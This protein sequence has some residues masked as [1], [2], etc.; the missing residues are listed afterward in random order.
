MFKR[1]KLCL[2]LKI[3]GIL[4][5]ASSVAR[6]EIFIELVDPPSLV[7]GKTN[8]I[9]LAGNDLQNAV[10]LWTSLG[11]DKVQ[12]KLVSKSDPH[13][14]IFDVQV[15][16]TTPLGFY[17]LRLATASGLSNVHLFL[18]D[19]LSI[20]PE[21]VKTNEASRVPQKVSLPAAVTG[22]SKNGE[23]DRFEISVSAN[24]SVSFEV[25]GSRLGKNFDPLVTIR[26]ERG[27]VIVEKDND[28][29]LF[30]DCRFEHRFVKAGNY[31]VELRDARYQG[32]D[33]LGYVL[34]MGRFPVARVAVPSSLRPAEE[35][36]V[37][38]PQLGG[39]TFPVVLSDRTV[40]RFAY[41]SLRRESDEASA[42]IPFQVSDLP[43]GLEREP[44]NEIDQA[45]LIAVPA[46]L[47]GLFDIPGDVDHFSL[48]LKKG[49]VLQFSTETRSL[50][51]PADVEL[52]L[53][54]PT[55]KE[56]KR[57]DDSGFDDAKF[58]FPVRTDG[59]HTL[60]VNDVIS[61]GGPEHIYQ[62]AVRLR[63]ARLVLNSGVTRLAIPQGTR[64][65]LPLT[66]SRLN[67]R[68]PVQLQLVGAPAGLRLQTAVIEEGQKDQANALIA[69]NVKPGIYTV[70]VQAT[71]VWKEKQLSSLARTAPMIDRL[72]T[73]RGPHGEPFALREDQRRLP[74][75]ISDRIAVLVTPS[76]PFD[77]ELAEDLVVLPRFL[78]TEFSINTTRKPGFTAPITFVVRGGTLE[79]DG[80]MRRQVKD[81][82][83]VATAEKSVAKGVFSSGVLS[84]P[85]KHWVTLT[86][87]AK[88]NDHKVSI[89]RMFELEIKPAYQPVILENPLEV[90]PG[91]TKEVTLDVN[92]IEPFDGEVTVT[93][94][95][96][97]GVTFP[98]SVIVPQGKS[99]VKFPIQIAK[100]YKTKK[101]TF[102][103]TGTGRV[104]RFQES[105]KGTPLV[106]QLAE[107]TK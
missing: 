30:F 100:D 33:N 11:D 8:R 26:D 67:F 68:G 55:G 102:A 52:V 41:Y 18:V 35:S 60:V 53:L 5:C 76:S 4:V 17:G 2:L 21:A 51:S 84:Q 44:N 36:Q 32:A 56:V 85:T 103:Y 40:G 50:G 49:Q 48:D 45:T 13:S 71:A 6:A 38:F 62:I 99:Q 81:S 15:P 77:F 74:P 58:D 9:K 37:M 86:G 59:A 1:S 29:G 93:F 80:Q 88:Q 28:V 83:E 66:L 97:P 75:S 79:Y 104:K 69:E 12:A 42:W 31:T 96:K 46:T 95:P 14:A 98:E 92:R 23:L 54:D 24:Q 105:V 27:R 73:G 39:E 101:T 22:I 43:A 3:F 47:N 72:P 78:S 91:E 25:V 65:P 82:L 106:I 70:Q 20:T 64:Q 10:G 94:T 87:T 16:E 107:P 7:R 57:A 19:D 90:K 34:R 63:E 89:T 61:A